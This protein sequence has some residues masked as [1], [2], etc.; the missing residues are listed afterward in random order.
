MV[1]VVKESLPVAERYIGSQVTIDKPH[2]GAFRVMEWLD[3]SWQRT[4]ETQD[5]LSHW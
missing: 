1:R 4:H 2:K 5:D 3:G